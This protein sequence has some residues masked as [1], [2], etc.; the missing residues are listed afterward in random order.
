MKKN[1]LKENINDFL[2]IAFSIL[3]G[4]LIMGSIKEFVNCKIFNKCPS[5]NRIDPQYIKNFIKFQSE[6]EK[7]REK[8]RKEIES[9]PIYYPL[10]FP[11]INLID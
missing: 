8:N 11:D 10:Q 6:M 2:L 4:T 5:K 1:T 9:Y 3:I 7:N